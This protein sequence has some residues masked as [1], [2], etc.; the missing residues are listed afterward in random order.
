MASRKRNITSAEGAE[1]LCNWDHIENEMIEETFSDS[2]SSSESE[3]GAEIVVEE[4]ILEDEEED[5]RQ[6]QLIPPLPWPSP[7][8]PPLVRMEMTPEATVRGK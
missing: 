6:Q 2:S 3:D 4:V 7:S 1:I 5:G 8:P